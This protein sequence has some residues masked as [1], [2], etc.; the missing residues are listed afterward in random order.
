MLN[1]T[2]GSRAGRNE[3]QQGG[4]PK[5][6]RDLRNSPLVIDTQIERFLVVF[7]DK[8]LL[9]SR[10]HGNDIFIHWVAVV[11]PAEAG[12]QYI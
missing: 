10:F 9:D 3:K 2:N 6:K 12:I 4:I 8:P 7:K 11:I 5:L 1:Y